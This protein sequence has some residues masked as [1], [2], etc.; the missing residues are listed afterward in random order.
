MAAKNNNVLIQPLEVKDSDAA[1]VANEV[2]YNKR[3]Y[4]YYYYFTFY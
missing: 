1:L 2:E 4:Y 3:F